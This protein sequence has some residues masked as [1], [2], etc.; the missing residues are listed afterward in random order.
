MAYVI[1]RNVFAIEFPRY[2]Q[3]FFSH[4][5]ELEIRLVGFTYGEEAHDWRLWISC[6][7][8]EW[9]GDFWSFVDNAFGA[10]DNYP[11]EELDDYHRSDRTRCLV[12]VPE[13]DTDAE[14]VGHMP[15]AWTESQIARVI[16]DRHIGYLLETQIWS[17]RQRRRTLRFLGFAKGQEDRCFG[18]AWKEAVR[19]R[20]QQRKSPHQV[21]FLDGLWLRQASSPPLYVWHH[22]RYLKCV[23]LSD[24]RGWI[25]FC[26]H[27]EG[28]MC[29][30]CEHLSGGSR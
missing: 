27:A 28:R 8:D 22:G 10:S 5:Q 21:F 1:T 16:I 13:S 11:S 6:P 30:D 15:G 2:R 7:L 9:A 17:R 26:V 3:N 4:R 19:L 14:G 18:P 29:H 24:Q 23:M 20:T 12:T 25:L